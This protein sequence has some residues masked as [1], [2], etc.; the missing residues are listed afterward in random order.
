MF[1]LSFSFERIIGIFSRICAS[2]HRPIFIQI[3]KLYYFLESTSDFRIFFF[4]V[5]LSLL[6]YFLITR[7]RVIVIPN[8]CFGLTSVF[9]SYCLFSPAPDLKQPCKTRHYELQVQLL[10][11]TLVKV[12]AVLL[13]RLFF[14]QNV[15]L[16]LII[17]NSSSL[18]QLLGQPLLCEGNWEHCRER[19]PQDLCE[20]NKPHQ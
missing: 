17:F 8:R 6:S 16:C 20:T 3:L 2:S 4:L 14:L 12:E 10:V 9:L 11:S 18:Q 13:H 7:C 5:C 1:L 19:D 15:P